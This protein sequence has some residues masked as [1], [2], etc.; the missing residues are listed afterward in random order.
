MTA[1]TALGVPRNATASSPRTFWLGVSSGF[2]KLK[3][4]TIQ[5]LT[6]PQMIKL[7]VL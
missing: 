6:Q 2:V 4:K 3:G 7:F 1:Y 5:S